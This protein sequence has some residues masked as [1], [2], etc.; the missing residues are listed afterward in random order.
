M[1]AIVA[2][3]VEVGKTVA[4]GKMAVIALVLVATAVGVAV[5]GNNPHANKI[6]N[7]GMT[8][9]NILFMRFPLPIKCQQVI[10]DMC[11]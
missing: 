9:I 3:G 8:T 2:L 4:V 1:T 6:N 5:D 7:T 11:K 10:N